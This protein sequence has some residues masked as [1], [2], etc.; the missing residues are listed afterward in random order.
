MQFHDKIKKLRKE[1]KWLQ[2]ELS[3]KVGIHKTHISRLESGEFLPS[4][5]VVKKIAEVFEVS[6]DYL[7]KDEMDNFEVK[8]KDKSLGERIRLIDNL[9]DNERQALITVIDAMLTK[10]RVLDLLT[11]EEVVKAVS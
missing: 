3:E 4:I 1:K 2:T 11:K 7:L 9:A 10:Q 6:T 8:I 5:K